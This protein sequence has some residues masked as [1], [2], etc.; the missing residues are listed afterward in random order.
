MTDEIC[1]EVEIATGSAWWILYNILKRVHAIDSC[2]QKRMA[3][4]VCRVSIS[5]AILARFKMKGLSWIELSLRMKPEYVPTNLFSKAKVLSDGIISKICMIDESCLRHCEAEDYAHNFTAIG[6]SVRLCAGFLRALMM[7][8]WVFV[9]MLRSAIAKNHAQILKAGSI[10]VHNGAVPHRGASVVQLVE[11]WG[12]E[13]SE[14]PPYSPDLLHAISI[15]IRSTQEAP[16]AKSLRPLTSF[17]EY[18]C[19]T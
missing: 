12:W 10:F 5:S 7:N 13:V 6:S 4:V 8:R 1:A 9:H 16:V 3:Q 2:A 11:E 15:S 19:R 14:H 17:I 18:T